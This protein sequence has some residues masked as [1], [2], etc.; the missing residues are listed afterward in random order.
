MLITTTLK[1]F[2]R[3]T[4]IQTIPSLTK[5]LKNDTGC[6]VGKHR[7]DDLVI[8][9]ISPTLMQ[10][11]MEHPIMYLQVFSMCGSTA[12]PVNQFHHTTSANCVV[13][14]SYNMKCLIILK[15]GNTA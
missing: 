11:L 3:G 13:W 8:C 2:S 9:H 10:R 4:S 6:V 12:V 5:M 14:F 15:D 7:L 1:V